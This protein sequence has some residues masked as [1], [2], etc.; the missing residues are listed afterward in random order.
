MLFGM[1]S[2]VPLAFG[3]NITRERCRQSL[4][5]REL[6]YRAGLHGS[7]IS[8]LERGQRDPRLSTVLRVAQALGV[9]AA[10]LLRGVGQP[11]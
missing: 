11:G 9:P 6:A 5:M 8:R 3:E 2:F 10:E 7:E 4:T 1:A